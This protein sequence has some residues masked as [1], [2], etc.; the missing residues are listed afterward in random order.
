MTAWTRHFI[1][2]QLPAILWAIVIFVGSSLPASK[3]PRILFRINDKLIH[4]SIFLVLGFFVYRAF[5]LRMRRGSFSW[6]RAI[7]TVVAV[8]AYGVLDELHQALVPGRTPDVWDAAA[9]A[10][11]GICSALVIYVLYRRRILDPTP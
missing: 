7:L 8:A 9:D 5:E 6:R 11:G 4:A 1:R 10:V 3:L 2:Y